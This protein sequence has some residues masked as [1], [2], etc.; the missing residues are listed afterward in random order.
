MSIIRDGA[1]RAVES[2]PRT[3]VAAEACRLGRNPN[4][5]VLLRTRKERKRAQNPFCLMV[6]DLKRLSN[7]LHDRPGSARYGSLGVMP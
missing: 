1:D 3:K 7:D 6:Q 5:R 4:D 2:V